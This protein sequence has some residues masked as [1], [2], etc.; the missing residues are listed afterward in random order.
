LNGEKAQIFLP[1][2]AP[3][4]KATLVKDW[5]GNGIA[6]VPIFTNELLYENLLF[7]YPVEISHTMV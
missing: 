5:N 6:I 7:V 1:D 2:T 3:P 4:D